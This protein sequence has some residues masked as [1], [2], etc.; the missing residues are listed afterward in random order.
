ME[1][2]AQNIQGL[3]ESSREKPVVLLFFA[4]QIPDS[5]AMK[6]QLEALA[7]R[8]AGKIELGTVDVGSP[9]N[10][11]LAQQ[12]QVRGIPAMKVIVDGQ[13]AS[14]A[15]GPQSPDALARL[16]DDLT[17]SPAER[18]R[19]SVEGMIADG[20]YG[21]AIAG[22]QEVLR[23]E[24]T[25]QAMRVELADLLLLTERTAEAEEILEALDDDAP[26][27]DRPRTRLAMKQEAQGF[28]EADLRNRV[29][30]G[31][32]EAAL[33]LA[34]VLAARGEYEAALE[35]LLQVMRRDREY[36]DDAARKEMVRVLALLR[37]GDGVGREYRKKMMNLLH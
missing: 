27:A 20:D 13:I 21:Q 14:E 29:S 3:L 22:L 5:V 23:E 31:D 25:N 1:V 24:P 9:Q 34:V 11:M 32:I 15:E 26:G 17:Q 18:V 10:Q 35:A 2:S 6:S 16:F 8:Y 36:G 19:E 12:L 37:P 28:D 4:A 7:G 30:E 33:Q